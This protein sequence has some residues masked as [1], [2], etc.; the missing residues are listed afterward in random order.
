MV[1]RT[2]KSAFWTAVAT[3]R[4]YRRLSAPPTAPLLPHSP[5]LTL[6][7]RRAFRLDLAHH[8]GARDLIAA[9]R[10]ATEQE[11]TPHQR[12][13]FVAIVL[14]GIALDALVVELCSNRTAIY[15]TMFDAGG[16]LRAA[17][18]AN[19]YG[20]SHFEAGMTDYPALERFLRTDPSDVGREQAVAVLHI[21]VDLVLDEPSGTVA[22]LRYPGVTA[23]LLACGPCEDDFQGL[24]SAASGAAA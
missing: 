14:K 16:K 3:A 19:G 20:R 8:G 2:R 11:F 24:L 17:L 13:V 5:E 1:S 22:P 7:R 23:H 4:F 18:A 10:Q 15:K 9:L 21:Y 6:T 12:Q